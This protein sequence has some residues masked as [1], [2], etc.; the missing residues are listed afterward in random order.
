MKTF[1]KKT[2]ILSGLSLLFGLLTAHGQRMTTYR[3]GITGG[4]N[5]NQIKND[6]GLQGIL[7]RYN[8]GIS[9]E[10]RFSPAIALAYQLVYSRQGE[11]VNNNYRLSASSGTV[12]NKQIIIFDYVAL[13]IMLRVR[14]KGERAF[15]EV[16][17]QVG[18]LI[19]NDF[20]F[21]N[22]PSSVP[23]SPIQHLTKIDAGLTGGVGYRLGEHLV[24]DARY[25]YG[26][27]P[28]LSDFSAINPQTGAST[29]Y[30]RE[31]WYNRVYL[32]NLSYYL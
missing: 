9:L 23:P 11:S 8:V 30:K 31:K 25:Y 14:P 15:L 2:L 4:L 17:G 20:Y 5:A 13:P 7:W 21:T 32:L 19:H 29:L 28:V 12:S 24:V 27:K 1:M 6:G 10:Q 26:M 3:F 18:T 16:G 22:P